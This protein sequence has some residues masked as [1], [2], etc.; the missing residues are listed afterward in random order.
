MITYPANLTANATYKIKRTS[1]PALDQV[2]GYAFE[3]LDRAIIGE[4]K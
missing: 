2:L 1:V 4:T 3:V